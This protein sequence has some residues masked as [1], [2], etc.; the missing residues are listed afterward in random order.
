MAAP[1]STKIQVTWDGRNTIPMVNVYAQT[2]DE[3]EILHEW[4]S[5]NIATLI[6]TGKQAHAA[7]AVMAAMPATT[8]LPAQPAAPAAAAAPAT[9][10]GHLCDCGQPMRLRSSSFGQFYSCAKPMSDATR[11]Q[12][13]VNVG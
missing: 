7:G 2:P 11:C 8:A 4:V 1:E 3:A 12:K 5:A 13:K 10:A 6:E 9:P